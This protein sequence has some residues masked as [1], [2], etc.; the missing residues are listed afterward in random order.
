MKK[1]R[2]IQSGLSCDDWI[3]NWTT[4]NESLAIPPLNAQRSFSKGAILFW[5]LISFFAAIRFV[6]LTADFP[7]NSPW[8]ED[9]AKFTDE[10]WW[11][12]SAITRQLSGHWTIPGDYN[13]AVAVPTWTALL[14]LVFRVTGV[15]LVSARAVSVLFSLGTIPLL[16][17]LVRRSTDAPN[18]L[19]ATTAALLLAASSFAF[20]FARLAILDSCVLFQFCLLLLVAGR[21]TRRLWVRMAVLALLVA[22]FILT[23]TTAVTLIPAVAWLALCALGLSLPNLAAVVVSVGVLPGILLAGWYVVVRATGHLIDLNYFFEINGMEPFDLKALPRTLLHL[24][25]NSLWIDPI[26]LLLAI[27]TIL[28][29]C[30]RLRPLWRNPLFSASVVALCSHMV[31]LIR[32]QDDTAPRYFLPLLIPVILIVVLGLNEWWNA[33]IES[34]DRP[35]VPQSIAV[36]LGVTVAW[37]GGSIVNYFSHP[38]FAYVGALNDTRRIIDSDPAQRRLVLGVSAADFSLATKIP[39]LNDAFGS[40]DLGEKVA[41]LKPGWF[42]AWNGVGDD[43][44]AALP[45]ELFVPVASYAVFDDPDRSTLILYKMDRRPE[46]REPGPPELH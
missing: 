43:I 30:F 15:S 46:T 28:L 40:E 38:T 14:T 8:A 12:N 1:S 10:G 26:L 3:P 4:L 37:Q 21:P 13:P 42:L 39:S 23:K 5:L 2:C 7:N 6:H 9:Q 18:Q 27:G 34:G 29:A 33:E 32:R 20:V 41:R 31:Y 19:P 16:Y 17:Q 36:L 11:A 24:A 35:W 44:H 45:D 25:Q 22:I